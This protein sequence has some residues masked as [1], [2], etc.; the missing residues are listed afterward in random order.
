MKKLYNIG[1]LLYL[2][3]SF[4]DN[5]L[6]GNQLKLF[7]KSG[8]I[9][10][11]SQS[12]DVISQQS[13]KL[14]NKYVILT[15]NEIPSNELKSELESAGIDLLNYLPDNSFYSYINQALTESIVMKANIHSINPVWKNTKYHPILIGKLP[16]WALTG[17]RI[18]LIVSYFH[19]R[20]SI[21][22]ENL[23]G[24]YN[25]H[26]T[27][28]DFDGKRAF[29]DI[30]VELLNSLGDA[31]FI[32]FIEPVD[33]PSQPENYGARSQH[34]SNMLAQ[35]FNSGNKF[36]GTG[37]A[38]GM[39]DDGIIGPHIDYEGRLP[40]QFPTTNG[41][42]H[43]DHVAGTIMGAGN[44]DPKGR[45]M[46]F[47]ADLY[48]YSSANNNYNNAVNHYN[49]YNVVITSKSYSNGCNAGYTSLSRQLDQQTRQNSS[50]IHVFS[51][52]NNGTS[53]CGYGAGSNWGNIT[54]GHK[55]GKN[56]IATG[57]LTSG[58]LIA[59][60]SSRG[61]ADDGRIKP[62]I[63]A[64]G[65]SVY[66][67]I[68]PNDY[69][70]KTGTS[71]ACPGISGSI[72]QLYHAYKSMNANQNPPSGLIK[73]V[74]LNTADDLGNPGPDFIYGWGRIN[75]RRALNVLENNQYS[76]ATITNLGNSIVPVSVPGN[77]KELRVMVYWH[78]FEATTTAAKAIVNNIDIVLTDPSNN[79]FLPWVLNPTPNVITLNSNAVRAVDSLNNMEQVTIDNP[80]SGIY[81]LSI[82]GTS[83]PQGPQQ[84]FI[85]YEFIFDEIYLTYPNGGEGLVPGE[86][87]V[88]RWDAYGSTSTFNVEYSS[89]GGSTWTTVSSNVPAAARQVNWVVPTSMTDAGRIRISRGL[90]NDVSD[91][92][93]T[94]IPVPTNLIVDWI[95][96]DSLKLSWNAVTS[97][98][99]FTAYMLGQKYMDSISIT[100]S[101]SYVYKNTDPNESYWVSVSANPPNGAS[102]RRAVAIQTPT[103]T[104]NCPLANDLSISQIVSPG[105]GT[106][107]ACILDSVELSFY[108]K[109][110]G[111]GAV[112]ASNI[113]CEV[114]NGV[115]LSG[116]TMTSLAPGDSVLVTIG[117]SKI[118]L[119]TA[120]SNIKCY[121]M[122]IADQNAY[123]DSADIRVNLV[124]GAIKN[125]PWD[126]DFEDFLNCSI[127]NDCGNTICPLFNDWI[128]DQTY[129]IDDHD[130][131]TDNGGTASGQTGP[132]IDHNPGNA[133]GNYMYL[134][135][136]VN[137]D[138]KRAQ[139]MTPCL[140]LTE[141]SMPRFTFWRHMYGIEMGALYVDLLTENGWVINVINP[142]AGNYGDRWIKDSIDLTPFTGGI[143]SV[144]FRGVTDVG[145]RGDMAL[146]DI[147]LFETDP[148]IGINKSEL[149]ATFKIFPNPSN[150]LIHIEFGKGQTESLAINLTDITGKNLEKVSTQRNGE[151][152]NMDLSRLENGIYFL[153]ISI[154]NEEY[155]EK[156]IKY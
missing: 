126:E 66:S 78:D 5:L 88:I 46:A 67:T 86:T 28:V 103:G 6:A 19:D 69:G 96:P 107:L 99:T 128:Q 84:C 24:S 15:F 50:L 7:L 63:C 62:D 20:S 14:K 11:N 106:Y 55:M 3:I 135:A 125:A 149:N 81:N 92:N 12:P 70:D 48:V 132:E 97:A 74:I 56:V 65:S 137:C 1:I 138:G 94:V 130:W 133:T 16:E 25:S 119:A 151:G 113:N 29:L 21:E 57:N 112:N 82:T 47:G 33:A 31:E 23:L 150:G 114:Y 36:D 144:R 120:L 42:D 38:I 104:F 95:C 60:S 64:K 89:N 153:K 140:D 72:G 148:Y 87:E 122:S 34:R 61:P 10:L 147:N 136:S 129:T 108:V 54:G 76:S 27:S 26:I 83:V 116:N 41:G 43:G 110:V 85:I 101:Q 58:D 17:D 53:D 39:H 35:E 79:T 105:N 2:S 52:G 100:G 93:F 91:E 30:P 154:G 68:D 143:V 49:T 37:V 145:Y 71:M 51:A 152:F 109:N 77:V 123:N 44:L 90:I 156:I 124:S 18:N 141:M 59:T 146:D 73:G 98:S 8:N 139:M 40:I 131:R 80:A 13:N 155:I 142:K 4:S 32:Y 102:G 45:G 118:D 117:T 127:D 111:L 75:L 121:I 22:L 134:E 115:T 9:E